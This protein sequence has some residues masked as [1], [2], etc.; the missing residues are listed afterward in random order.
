M[1]H[2]MSQFLSHKTRSASEVEA[3]RRS[4]DRLS[5]SSKPVLETMFSIVVEEDIVIEEEN[6][7]MK[8]GQSGST[9]STPTKVNIIIFNDVIVK[10]L[11]II[12][13]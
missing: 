8:Q 13:N 12:N 10:I 3:A 6:Q 7:A 1:A 9:S 11:F 2:A 4:I 5:P